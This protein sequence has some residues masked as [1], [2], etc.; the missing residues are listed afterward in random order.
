MVL[1]DYI[2]LLVIGMAQFGGH[3]TPWQVIPGVV[4]KDGRL[5]RPLAYIHGCAWNFLG[6]IA[7]ALAHQPT[8]DVWL[9]VLFVGSGLVASFIGTMLPRAFNLIL[10]MYAKSGDIKD[11]EEM[12]RGDG[13]TK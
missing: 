8:V 10:E 12:V 13:S 1:S 11:L 5:H 6:F 7:F 3:Y 4:N 9:A 2:A